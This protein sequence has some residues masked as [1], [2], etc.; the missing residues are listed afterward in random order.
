MPLS[1]NSLYLKNFI[2]FRNGPVKKP[3]SLRNE[4]EIG[5]KKK[6]IQPLQKLDFRLLPAGDNCGIF[7]LNFLFTADGICIEQHVRPSMWLLQQFYFIFFF[8]TEN[9]YNF[10]WFY[11]TVLLRL[12]QNSKYHP[13]FFLFCKWIVETRNASLSKFKKNLIERRNSVNLSNFF[14]LARRKTKKMRE[15]VYNIPSSPDSQVYRE[16]KTFELVSKGQKI[17][18]ICKTGSREPAGEPAVL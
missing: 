5:K 12:I 2:H 13:P 4:K 1:N 10:N 18:G 14:S 17:N 15:F 7:S 6:K 3:P 16:Q 9:C 8:K 11:P